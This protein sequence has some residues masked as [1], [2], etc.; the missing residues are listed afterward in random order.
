M[1]A[2]GPSLENPHVRQNQQQKGLE[3]PEMEPAG[4]QAWMSQKQVRTLEDIRWY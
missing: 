4:N 2:K 3:G 1:P